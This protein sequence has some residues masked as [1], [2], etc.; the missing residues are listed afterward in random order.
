MEG[1]SCTGGITGGKRGDKVLYPAGLEKSHVAV[2][3]WEIL[4]V[5]FESHLQACLWLDISV[6]LAPWLLCSQRRSSTYSDYTPHFPF[7]GSQGVGEREVPGASN[8]H[9]LSPAWSSIEPGRT[10]GFQVPT[11]FTK[12]N[13]ECYLE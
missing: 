11:S 12:Q 8:H 1:S 13:K 10:H 9:G 2:H 5:D 6:Q 4:N 3:L 7:W